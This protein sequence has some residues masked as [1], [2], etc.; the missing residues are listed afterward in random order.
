MSVPTAVK[1]A[2]HFGVVLLLNRGNAEQKETQREHGDTP[3]NSHMCCSVC[4]DL[5][6]GHH[7][8]KGSII[9]RI[10]R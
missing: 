2:I 10:K 6:P 4:D 9:K 3:Q 5:E 7:C 8:L 1:P